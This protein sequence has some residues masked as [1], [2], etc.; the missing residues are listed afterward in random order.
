MNKNEQTQVLERTAETR[1]LKT[2]L[3]V[4]A[5]VFGGQPWEIGSTNVLYLLP[6]GILML[7]C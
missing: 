3:S 1:V 4:N 7:R 5:A 2:Q 6:C